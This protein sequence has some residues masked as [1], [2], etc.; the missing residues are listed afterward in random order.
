MRLAMGLVLIVFGV[1]SAGSS[2]ALRNAQ[3]NDMPP[4]ERTG[5]AIGGAL[6]SLTLVG[7]GFYLARSGDKKSKSPKQ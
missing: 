3:P 5:Q 7:V 6:F 4:A 1:L 2:A